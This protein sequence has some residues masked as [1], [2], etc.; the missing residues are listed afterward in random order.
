M[1]KKKIFI[2]VCVALPALLLA[3]GLKI[4]LDS[5]YRLP[6]LMYHSI[7]YA[8]DKENRMIIAPETFARQMKFLHDHRYNVI[9]VAEAVSYIRQQKA[10]PKT[11]AITIDDGYAD[12]YRY[13]YPVLKQYNIPATIF[14]IV[15]LVGREGFLNW[16]E[17][18]EMSDSGIIDIE[19]HTVSH[20]WLTGEKDEA[21]KKELEDSKQI[22]EEKLGKSVSF[23]CYPMGGYDE[24]VKRAAKEAGYKAAF[25]TKPARLSPDCDVYEIKRVR[26]SSTASNMFVFWIKLSGY[27]AFF[28]VLQSERKD[29]P[30]I[31]WKKR[32]SS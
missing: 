25:A 8:A 32:S 18:R 19:S 28:K 2:F 4:F 9:P 17:I 11:V 14:V 23:L 15:S 7:D 27:H 5:A 13:A 3:A 24:R 16:D 20:P 22:L 26:I 10:P 21:L 31:L 12:N 30:Y 6:V 1:N 29:R